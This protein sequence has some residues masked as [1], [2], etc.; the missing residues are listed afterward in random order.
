MARVQNVLGNKRLPA[1]FSGHER[2]GSP[3]R[4]ERTS[5]VAFTYDPATPRLLIMAPHVTD[6]REPTPEEKKNLIVLDEALDDLRELRAGS[7]GH[8]ALRATWVDMEVDPLTAPSRTWESVTAYQVT[9]HAKL[10]TAAD[11]L[12]EDLRAECCRRRLPEPVVKPL[13]LP[14]VPDVGLVGRA[15]L[16]FAVALT[17]PIVLGKSRYVGGGLFTGTGAG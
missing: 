12:S 15:R 4:S 3:A 14:G 11:A 9:R 10:A 17:G 6:Q 16:L 1:F 2:D 7:A 5:H 8:L 13:E